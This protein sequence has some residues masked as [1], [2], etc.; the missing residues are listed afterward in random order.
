[1]DK[2]LK[3]KSVLDKNNEQKEKYKTQN[4]TPNMFCVGDFV[5]II[6]YGVL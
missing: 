3:N 5:R 4:N 1:M 2:G 6:T